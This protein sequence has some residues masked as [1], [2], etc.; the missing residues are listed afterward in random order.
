MIVMTS[1]SGDD[2]EQK[3]IPS[4]KDQKIQFYHFFKFIIDL[5]LWVNP[6]NCCAKVGE[7][8]NSSFRVL[9]IWRSQDV[10]MIVPFL[11]GAIFLLFIIK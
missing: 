4:F 2:H 6:M 10:Y 3:Q 1:L 8:K 9:V 5:M 7:C 11:F